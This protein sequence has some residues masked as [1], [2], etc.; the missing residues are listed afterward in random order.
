MP[1]NFVVTN[2]GTSACNG[3]YYADG[4]ANGFPKYK[5]NDSSSFCWSSPDGRWL[6]YSSVGPG[7]SETY[8]YYSNN[9]GQGESDPWLQTWSVNAGTGT[10]PAPELTVSTTPPPTTPP[11]TTPPATTA[12]PIPPTGDSACVQ[13]WHKLG[14]VKRVI[15]DITADS[16]DGSVDAIDL[17]QGLDGFLLRL[18]TVPGSPAPSSNYD[19]TLTNADGVDMLQG[20]G[21]N[22]SSSAAQDARIVYSGT[23]NHPVV[24]PSDQLTLNVANNSEAGAAIRVELYFGCI[25][26]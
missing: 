26:N 21:A 13:S 16:A 20:V 8:W 9:N 18:A 23:A 22:R 19:L 5:K 15:F 4:T 17:E 11:P 24:A 2:A 10:A 6:F 7:G 1:S 12:P 3:T 14:T 25:G